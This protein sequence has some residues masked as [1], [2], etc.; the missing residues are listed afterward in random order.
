MSVEMWE[1]AWTISRLNSSGDQ[2]LRQ[3]QSLN[4]KHGFGCASVKRRGEVAITGDRTPALG[5]PQS[6]S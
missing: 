3:R 6:F 1:L 2:D 4:S 5:T